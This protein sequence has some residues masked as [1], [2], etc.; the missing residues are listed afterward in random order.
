MKS[1]VIY[2]SRN[3]EN[4]MNDGIKNIEIGNTEIIAN[5]I[6]DIIGADLFKVEPINEYPYNY[7]ECCDLAKL[8]LDT[9]FRPKVKKM[10]N[11]IDNYDVIYIG[12]PIWWGHYPCSLYTVLENLDFKGKIV[13]PFS[14]HEGSKLGSIMNDINRICIGSDIKEGLA[15]LG[16]EA[17]NSKEK[18]ER[19]C[20]ND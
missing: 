14:T 9:N 3:E 10:L 12:G 15:I 6:K 2:F 20:K 17:R 1:L 19:W 11:N 13:K 18:L 16:S 7:K 5:Y 8:E 4:Y